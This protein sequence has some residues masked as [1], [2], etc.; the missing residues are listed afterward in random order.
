[1]TNFSKMFSINFSA[2]SLALLAWA[3]LL[4]IVPGPVMV[5]TVADWSEQFWANF[6]YIFMALLLIIPAILLW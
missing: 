6:I 4:A 2:K 1:M 5:Q 3:Q